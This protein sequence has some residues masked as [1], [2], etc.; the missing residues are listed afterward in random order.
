[1]KAYLKSNSSEILPVNFKII[2]VPIFIFS[3]K[4]RLNDLK[5]EFCQLKL[6]VEAQINLQLTGKISLEFHFSSDLLL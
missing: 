3:L 4:V 5:L 1:M 2:Y 6:G